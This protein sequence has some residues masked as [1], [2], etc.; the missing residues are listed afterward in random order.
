MRF[1]IFAALAFT[2]S[3][4]RAQ[5]TPY[6]GARSI[7]KADSVS[8][9]GVG[10]GTLELDQWTGQKFILLPMSAKVEQYGYQSLTPN[11][12]ASAAGTILTVTSIE[13][14]SALPLVHFRSDDGS[15]IEATAYTGSIEG[16]APIR[17]LDFARERWLGHTLWL[18]VP[19]IVTYDAEK[20]VFGSVKLGRTARVDVKDVIAGW[21]SSEPVR[22]ILRSDDGRE[23][24]LDLQ[25]SGTN[26]SDIL[27][28]SESS[29]L[30]ALFYES[31]PREKHK[32]WPA[33]VWQA[34]AQ[35]KVFV[36]MMAEQAE[37][38]W[39]KPGTVN[40]IVTAG[41]RSE[42]WVYDAGTYLY[43]SDGIVTSIQN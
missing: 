2:T 9:A 43:V 7:G 26:V 37:M 11:L 29:Q 12:P 42:Q 16:I 30:G 31:D 4:L 14:L 28:D 25:V 33:R 1:L 20:D 36:G 10:P 27:R 39:G 5:R 8:K 34:I 22:F 40:R 15:E 17:D 3:T 41:G 19:E 6:I 13:K 24:F 38:S 21:Y 18:R 32:D 23:G 35:E